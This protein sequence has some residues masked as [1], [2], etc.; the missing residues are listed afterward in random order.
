MPLW[1]VA[2]VVIGAE[3]TTIELRMVYGSGDAGAEA[4][5]TSPR[6]VLHSIQGRVVRDIRRRS[7]DEVDASNLEG[8]LQSVTQEAQEG[9]AAVGSVLR[10]VFDTAAAAVAGISEAS[11]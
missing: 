2:E 4:G 5:V 7:V 10:F 1:G 11:A 6:S 9:Q 3:D 8:S